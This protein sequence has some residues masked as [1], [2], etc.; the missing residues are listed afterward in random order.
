VNESWGR[1]FLAR[2][3]QTEPNLERRRQGQLD[4]ALT[5]GGVEQAHRHAVVLRPYAIDGIFTSPLG[6]AVATADI[7]GAHLGPAVAV[8]DELTE[9]I[10]D[11]SPA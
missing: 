9:V 6:R 5:A 7:I 3:G 11:A 1:V 8:V 4:S 2:H 10:T